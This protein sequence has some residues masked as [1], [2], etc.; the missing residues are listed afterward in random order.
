MRA[1]PCRAAAAALLFI[2]IPTIGQTAT[3]PAQPESKPLQFEVVSIRQNKTGS[4]I[5]LNKTPRDGYEV[6]NMLLKIL[7]SGAYGIRPDLTSGGPDWIHTAHYDIRAKVAEEDLAAYR[8][9]SSKQ[10]DAM[11]QAVLADRFKL[12]AHIETKQLPCY[13]LV[14]AKS[15]P[16][17]QDS[18]LTH[19]TFGANMGSF[20]TEAI[21]MPR[22]AEVLS[23]YLQRTVADRTGLTG[24]YKFRLEW[25]P[26]RPIRSTAASDSPEA[27][28][29]VGPSLFTAVEEQLGLKLNPTRGPVDTLVIDHVEPPSEN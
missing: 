2:T 6:E 7:I 24:M 8:A 1:R 11:V 25:T 21:H 16:K 14:V 26:D 23:M 27:S 4:Y 20:F 12:S 17:L 3:P 13:E 18:T 5:S 22:F 10:R 19:E 15:G 29:P 9:L 28:E